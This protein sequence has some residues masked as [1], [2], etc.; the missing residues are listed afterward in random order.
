M[1]SSFEKKNCEICNRE[2]NKSDDPLSTDC[3]GDCWGCVG[4]I[5]ALGGY[6]ESLEKV[7]LEI[8]KG[9]RPPLDGI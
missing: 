5:E 7:R 8:E 3:G 4:E 1:T 2:L 9:I 6:S